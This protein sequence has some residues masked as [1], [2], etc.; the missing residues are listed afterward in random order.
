M[1]YGRNNFPGVSLRETPRNRETGAHVRGSFDTDQAIHVWAQRAQTYGQNGK[2]NVY[3][4][5]D[6]LYSYG[7]HFILGQFV[8]GADGAPVVLLNAET[9]SVSTSAH[10]ATTRGAVRQYA[11]VFTVPD[12]ALDHVRN[13]ESYAARLA[14]AERAAAKPWSPAYEGARNWSAESFAE[15]T[16]ESRAYAKAF[17]LRFAPK[18]EAARAAAAAER[19]RKADAKR[20]RQSNARDARAFAAMTDSDWADY[21]RRLNVR[22]ANGVQPHQIGY[23]REAADEVASK[24]FAA[25][26]DGKAQGVGKLA[27]AKLAARRKAF[28]GWRAGIE[29]RALA[30][31]RAELAAAFAKWALANATAPDVVARAAALDLAHLS[32]WQYPDGS[33][34]AAALEAATHER[35]AYRNRQRAEAAALAF[36]NWAPTWQAAASDK[37]K[38]ATATAKGRPSS[39]SFGEDSAAR[40]LLKEAEAFAYSPAAQAVRAGAAAEAFED[41]QAGRRHDCPKPER[42]N[43]AAF[44]RRLG[45]ELATSMGASVP[46]RHAVRAFQFV[47]L[48]RARG[49]GWRANGQSVRVGHFHVDSISREGDMR[50]GCHFFEWRDMEA[51]AKREGV[52]LAPSA[53]AVEGEHA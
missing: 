18:A 47:A 43:G 44:V 48:C 22:D 25:V 19:E 16:A 11:R 33:A 40:A 3:F 28:N 46:W 35:D 41:W 7:T 15:L 42:K 12:A 13:L 5:G 8:D 9:H 30:A 52:A 36:A 31:H 45:D 53:S 14:V 2:G 32:P 39:Y 23:A 1:A 27:L 37:A 6:V 10:Q 20:E 49:K 24:L 34:E 21:L 50:A 51:L 29:T 17:G 26:R 38:L 4:R